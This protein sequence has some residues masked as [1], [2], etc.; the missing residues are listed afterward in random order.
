MQGWWDARA[1]N[2][3]RF[4]RGSQGHQFRMEA[5]MFDCHGFDF[6]N[7]PGEPGAILR[8]RRAYPLDIR[9]NQGP[10]NVFPDE[11][12]ENDRLEKTTG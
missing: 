2:E 11:R 8:D 9:Q 5:R 3:M 7:P 6:V 10:F 4:R 12:V 1:D